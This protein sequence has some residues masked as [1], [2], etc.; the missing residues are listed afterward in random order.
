[1]KNQ[2]E[3]LLNSTAYEAPKCET[4]EVQNEGVLCE[5]GAQATNDPFVG[6]GNY[7]W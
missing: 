2:N 4:I 5:S 1:M 7:E 6:S 3:D